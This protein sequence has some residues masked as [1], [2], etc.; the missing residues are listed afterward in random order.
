MERD[1]LLFLLLCSELK[2]MYIVAVL[3]SNVVGGLK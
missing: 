2:D 1:I 3:N